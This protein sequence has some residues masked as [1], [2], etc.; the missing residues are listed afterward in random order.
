[1]ARDD[2]PDLLFDYNQRLLEIVNSLYPK[3]ILVIGGGAYTLPSAIITA[4]PEVRVDVVELDPGLLALAKQYF[5]L[6]ENDRMNI[7]HQDGRQFLEESSATYDMWST[8]LQ[9]SNTV[10]GGRRT[11]YRSHT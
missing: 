3:N 4:L 8:L 9:T 6:P 2:L 11:S 10:Y 5:G 1:M 7:V